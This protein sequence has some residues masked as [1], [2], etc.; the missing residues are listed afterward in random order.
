MTAKAIQS[1]SSFK[2]SKHLKLTGL[3]SEI[4]NN[5]LETHCCTCWTTKY[6]PPWEFLEGLKPY[7]AFYHKGN[8]SCLPGYSTDTWGPIFSSHDQ[9]SHSSSASWSL[10]EVTPYERKSPKRNSCHMCMCP[11]LKSM[12]RNYCWPAL[13][14]ILKHYVPYI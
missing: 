5:P 3:W 4:K 6:Q 10:Q 13:L 2:G 1:S 14:L 12:S 7:Q 11:K 8:S 9:T